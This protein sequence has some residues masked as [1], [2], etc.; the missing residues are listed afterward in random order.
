MDGHT[1]REVMEGVMK[2]NRIEFGAFRA[3]DIQGNGCRKLMSFGGEITKYITEF[4]QSMPEGQ[5]NY[6]DKEI[7]ELF[8]VYARFL[9]RL[10]AFFSIICKKR[11]HLNDSDVDKAMLHCDAIENLWRY[12]KMS[13]TPKLHLLFV[14]F[15]IFLEQVHGFGDLREDSGEPAHQE[16]A[17]NESQ[18]GAVVNL[19]KKERTKSQF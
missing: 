16:E 7:C 19:A 9:G 11:F 12:L 1:V 2:D 8:R 4:L 5:K 10:E 6:S 3:G 17:R 13:V 18:V 15:L 14:H